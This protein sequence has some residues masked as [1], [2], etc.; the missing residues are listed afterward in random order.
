MSEEKL[1]KSLEDFDEMRK[2]MRQYDKEKQSDTYT[3]SGICGNCGHGYTH[4]FPKGTK[5]YPKPCPRCGC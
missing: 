1:P 3:V 2:R 5:V 4:E